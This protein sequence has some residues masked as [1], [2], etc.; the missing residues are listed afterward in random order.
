MHW[1]ISGAEE[2]T[3]VTMQWEDK[4]AFAGF[5]TRSIKTVCACAAASL[6][7]LD[8]VGGAVAGSSKSLRIDQCLKQ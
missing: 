3:S 4:D 7:K 8:P 5:G 6:T 1:R 2:L